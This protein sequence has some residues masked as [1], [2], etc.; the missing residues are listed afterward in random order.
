MATKV[1]LPRDIIGAR[2]LGGFGPSSSSS[3]AALFYPLREQTPNSCSNNSGGGPSPDARPRRKPEARRRRGGS[4]KI[5]G[6]GNGRGGSPVL[7]QVSILRRGESIGPATGRKGEK[8]RSQG[9]AGVSAEAR[10]AEIYAGPAFSLSPSPSALPL[11][12][13]SSRKTDQDGAAAGSH[14]QSATRDL[15]RLLRLD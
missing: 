3:A 10:R 11:P 5:G 9:P 2:R 13:F 12:S 15:R 7:R 14:H 6:D 8:G 4:P 1:L